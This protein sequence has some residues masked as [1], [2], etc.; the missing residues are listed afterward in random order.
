MILIWLYQDK[1]VKI[2][3]DEEEKQQ[4]LLS[5]KRYNEW[6][7]KSVGLKFVGGCQEHFHPILIYA[8]EN[9]NR[10]I[11]EIILKS[12]EIIIDKLYCF[13]CDYSVFDVSGFVLFG[14]KKVFGARYSTGGKNWIRRISS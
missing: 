1:Y 13:L 8:Q 14:W 7:R 3:S 4:F 6:E 2:S 12:C 9:I 5:E 11:I 10:T